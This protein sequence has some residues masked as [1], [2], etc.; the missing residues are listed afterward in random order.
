MAGNHHVV[1]QNIKL[2]GKL[3]SSFGRLILLGNKGASGKGDVFVLTHSLFMREHISVT[4]SKNYWSFTTTENHGTI[5]P[6]EKGER[7]RGKKPQVCLVS[8]K[9][10][11]MN[12]P[13]LHPYAFI[14]L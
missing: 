5:S 6:E 12:M 14:N 11:N 10:S 4:P 2:L 3:S 7:W 9:F 1:S 13:A 8:L